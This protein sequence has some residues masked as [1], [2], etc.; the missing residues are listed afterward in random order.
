MSQLDAIYSNVWAAHTDEFSLLDRSLSPRSW[1][2]LFDVA[3]DV[4]LGPHSVVADV[5]CG[6]GNHCAELAKR[7]DCRAVGIDIV[8]Q[9]LRSAFLERTPGSRIEFIQ[10]DIERLPIRTE[11]VDFVWCRDILVHVRDLVSGIG[12]CSRILRDHGK[13]LVWI[14]VATDLMEPREAER[15]Y[16]PLNI[17]AASMSLK[18]L[19]AAFLQAG[20]V[21][22]RVEMVGSELME[23]YEERDGRASRELMRLAR[24][25]R[26]REPLRAQ[27]GSIKYD[28]AHALYEWA[29][30]LLL[31]KLNSGFYL[32]EKAATIHGRAQSSIRWPTGRD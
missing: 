18:N 9:P 12:E 27:W 17:S 6:R 13:M 28:S 22:S 11:S 5:G 23:F 2:L 16:G 3:A 7:F 4:G 30:Y 20:L 24:M 8:F 10:G 29:I 1:S 32:L 14:T 19:E 21:V 25:R 15:L 31:G 26:M